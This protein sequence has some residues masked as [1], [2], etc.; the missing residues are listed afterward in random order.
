MATAKKA[1]KKATKV[2][3]KVVVKKAKRSNRPAVVAASAIPPVAPLHVANDTF[4]T[5]RE[6]Q[7]IA[8]GTVQIFVNGT[9][10]GTADCSGR[11]LGEFVTEVATKYGVRN[12]TVYADGAKVMTDASGAAL[13]D[14]NRP[15]GKLEIIAKDSRA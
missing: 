3:K 9:D 11:K 8:R 4:S 10:K 2:A 15:V 6:A 14:A 12:F 5:Q 13:D 7:T 1:T